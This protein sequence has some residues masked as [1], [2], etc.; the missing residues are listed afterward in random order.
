[1]GSGYPPLPAKPQASSGADPSLS[2]DEQRKVMELIANANP[3]QVAKLKK[4]IEGA[5]RD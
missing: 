5:E 2:L 1:M 3:E 4:I